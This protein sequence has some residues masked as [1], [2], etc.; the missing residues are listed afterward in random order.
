MVLVHHLG[1]KS[2]QVYVNPLAYL[3]GENDDSIYLFAAKGGAPITGLVPQ[4]RRGR[5]GHHRG[6]VQHLPGHRQRAHWG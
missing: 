3:P 2:G 4:P 6:G 5:R 1:R